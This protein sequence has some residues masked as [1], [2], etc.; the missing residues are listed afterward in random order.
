MQEKFLERLREALENF[1]AYKAEHLSIEI[2][3]AED[4]GYIVSPLEDNL[5]LH[6]TNKIVGNWRE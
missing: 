4:N 5:W 2:H 1:D 6:L 3:N